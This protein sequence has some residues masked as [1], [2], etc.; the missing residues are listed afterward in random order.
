[1]YECMI[2]YYII[3][4]TNTNGMKYYGILRNI[5]IYG[6][7]TSTVLFSSLVIMVLSYLGYKYININY[8]INHL[9]VCIYKVYRE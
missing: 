4:N 5:C 8:I 9:N 1:M 7:N 3:V 2:R 6:D